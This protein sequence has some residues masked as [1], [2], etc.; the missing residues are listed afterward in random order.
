MNVRGF[1]TKIF[2]LLI[3][4]EY[5]Y[6]I[7]RA[8]FEVLNHILFKYEIFNA[9]NKNQKINKINE[10]E[11]TQNFINLINDISTKKKLVFLYYQH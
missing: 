8:S 7:L 2:L 4:P 5:N 6:F 11:Q 9:Y 1:N 3:K 10:I